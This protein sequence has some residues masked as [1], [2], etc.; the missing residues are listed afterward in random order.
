MGPFLSGRKA[1]HVRERDDYG[2]S[3][4][5]EDLKLIDELA[6]PVKDSLAIAGKHRTKHVHFG[7]VRSAWTFRQCAALLRDLRCRQV[8]HRQLSGDALG[9][10]SESQ[11]ATRHIAVCTQ[12][13]V[14]VYVT[15]GLH[16]LEKLAAAAVDPEDALLLDL[17]HEL[18]QKRL[19][20]K[21][22]MLYEKL[23]AGVI[24]TE[25][26]SALGACSTDFTGSSA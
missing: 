4:T 7:T 3:L 6:L 26:K 19:R 17:R 2:F 22:E 12:A 20:R 8:H 18:E 23:F 24:S 16:E 15:Y 10:H 9:P 11:A 5:P 21:L 1:P 14:N 25:Q 13:G